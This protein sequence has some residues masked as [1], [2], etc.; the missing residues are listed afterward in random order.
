MPCAKRSDC[1]AQFAVN[2]IGLSNCTIHTS[3]GLVVRCL[4]LEH[5]LVYVMQTSARPGVATIRPTYIR[6][7]IKSLTH[8]K[9]FIGQTPYIVRIEFV[10]K[11]TTTTTAS[12]STQALIGLC[13]DAAWIVMCIG[14]ETYQWM[15]IICVVWCE[16]YRG[17]RNRLV[18]GDLNGLYM[19][20]SAYVTC[21]LC[22]FAC[23]CTLLA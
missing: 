7:A 22:L 1:F 8:K 20:V 10:I 17:E 21:L 6:A 15:E 23:I 12:K 2:D 9:R 13:I 5:N 18:W 4:A 3:S 19:C 11:A 16:N 14:G